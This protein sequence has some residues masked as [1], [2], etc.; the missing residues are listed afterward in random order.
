MFVVRLVDRVEPRLS[1]GWAGGELEVAVGSRE[2]ALALA[3]ALL[4]GAPLDHRAVFSRP[5]AGGLRTVSV[6]ERGMGH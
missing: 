5:L 1:G 3:G 4:E 2:Q 6:E